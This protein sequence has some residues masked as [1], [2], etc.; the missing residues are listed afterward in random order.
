MAPRLFLFYG[1]EDFLIT[2]A[3]NSVKNEILGSGSNDYNFEIIDG[4]DCDI[5]AVVNSISSIGMFSQIKVVVIENYDFKSEEELL[6]A[7]MN[8]SPDTYLVITSDSVPRSSKLV[9]HVRKNG[10]ISEFKPFSVWEEDRTADWI[11]ENAL[12]QG[13]KISRKAAYLLNA[14]S[15]P[16]LRLL[17][18]EIKKLSAFAGSRNEITEDD[19]RELSVSGELNSFALVNAVR[20]R[21][22]KSAI[23]SLDR[24][25]K[26]KE[27]PESIVGGVSSLIVTMLELKSD[28][29]KM[30]MHGASYYLRQCAE[31][32][33]KYSVH[34]LA[35]AVACLH[36][37]DLKLK[38]TM[39]SQQTVLEMMLADIIGLPAGRQGKKVA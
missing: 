11:I 25:L 38:N 23:F 8:I 14:V 17:D 18:S 7:I 21:D 3:V 15:G 12:S 13:T 26:A 27:R 29:S 6:G 16:S 28:K 1:E 10:K 37:A 33:A 36:D 31:G 20:D 24:F 39:Q 2:E 9:D 30:A 19:I 4:E 32:A 34:E 35:R 22:L 5:D